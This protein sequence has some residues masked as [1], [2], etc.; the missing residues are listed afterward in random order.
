VISRP[1]TEQV[2]LDCCRVLEDDVL[3][4]VADETMQVRL[5]MLGKVL[6]NAAVRAAHEVAWMREETAAVEA[7]ARAV[8]ATTGD[9][10]LRTALEALAE[11]PRGSLHLTDVV[12][13][14]VRASDVLSVALEVALAA[15]RDDL[16]REGESLLT[17][18][19]AHEEDVVGGWDS[20]GR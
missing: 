17:T 20:A 4:A 8:A 11:G 9:D 3:P 15:G 12:E 16:V 13:V 5:V 19:L 7:Y 18:R 10:G 1:T 2:L 6:R 14:Y